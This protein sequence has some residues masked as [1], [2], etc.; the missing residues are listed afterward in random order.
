MKGDMDAMNSTGVV[1]LSLLTANE[2]IT[3][4][5]IK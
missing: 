5:P 2:N 3:A 1:V 4:N